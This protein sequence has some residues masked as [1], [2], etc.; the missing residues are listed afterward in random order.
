MVNIIN[1][2]Q[3]NNQFT[4]TQTLLAPLLISDT[5]E[6]LLFV[7]IQLYF[8]IKIKL[9]NGINELRKDTSKVLRKTD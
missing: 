2:S 6:I 5:I 9:D 1:V 7:Y 4:C 8:N 3:P